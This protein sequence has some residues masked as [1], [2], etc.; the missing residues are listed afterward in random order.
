MKQN[1]KIHIRDFPKEKKWVFCV[2]HIQ[3]SLVK[4]GY[5]AINAEYS[6]SFKIINKLLIGFI[7][8]LLKVTYYY[9]LQF[10]VVQKKELKNK[11]A[12]F[13]KSGNGYDYANLYRVVDFDES[14]VVYINSFTMKSYMGVV[15]VG[16]LT[17]I[18]VFVRSFIVYC[19]VIKNNLP[20]NIEN[21]VIENG[22]RNI[23]QYTYL[24]SFF[25]TVKKSS[26]N[27]QIYTGGS[28]LQSNAA[29]ESNLKTFYLMH[30]LLGRVHPAIFP[31][32]SE[33][34]VYN[35]DEKSYLEGL[36]V[37]SNILIYPFDKLHTMRKVVLIFMRINDELMDFNDIYDLVQ[38][39]KTHNYDI[40][41]KL[42]PQ[43]RDK[44]AYEW[45]STL[46]IDII[47]NNTGDA[48]SLI[49][50]FSPSFVVA[51]RSTALCESLNM[52][53]MPISLSK[54]SD[55]T[56]HVVYPIAKRALFWHEE[57]EI[58]NDAVEATAFY[59]EVINTLKRP[60]FK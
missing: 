2:N 6:I 10:L 4:L 11:K 42:H 47:G 41:M 8:S 12:I 25:K 30:G 26:N 20:N 28:W 27:I 9:F 15:K 22:L 33:V 14:K 53:V 46:S 59:N 48:T 40:K 51:W 21:L 23:A 32:F 37:K 57:K 43:Y 29:I 18:D 13:L 1:S 44:N 3:R 58:I 24:S 60:E 16:F 45:A 55:I 5:S 36:G 7:F 49:Y 38:F 19:S 56:S 17:L 39:F 54:K 31:E 35:A 50:S 52:G 34:Y